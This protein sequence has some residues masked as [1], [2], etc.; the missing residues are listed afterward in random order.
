MSCGELVEV[1]VGRPEHKLFM[2]VLIVVPFL[3]VCL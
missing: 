3:L 1:A 2:P